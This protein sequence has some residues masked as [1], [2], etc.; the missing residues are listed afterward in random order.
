MPCVVGDRPGHVAAPGAD[1]DG[2]DREAPGPLVGPECGDG[3]GDVGGLALRLLELARLAPALPEGAMV[4]GERGEAPSRQRPR[5]GA[6]GLLL[7]RRER[8]RR[9]DH[10]HRPVHGQV[11]RPNQLVTVS[12]EGEGLGRQLNHGHNNTGTGHRIPQVASRADP[13]L[14]VSAGVGC[15]AGWWR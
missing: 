6:G 3:G 8:A 11:Q 13:D 7:H 14:E 9:D 4:E 10:G 2:D 1:A 15:V 12:S 5:V